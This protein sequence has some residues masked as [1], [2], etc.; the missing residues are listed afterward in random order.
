ME[1]LR[2][3][4]AI[5]LL[6]TTNYTNIWSIFLLDELNAEILIGFVNVVNNKVVCKAEECK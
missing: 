4:V 6:K 1:Y 5:L 2:P 3:T